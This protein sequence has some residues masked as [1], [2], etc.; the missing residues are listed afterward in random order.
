MSVDAHIIFNLVP[1]F[2]EVSKFDNNLIGFLFGIFYLGTYSNILFLRSRYVCTHNM[3]LTYAYT[4]RN[5]FQNQHPKENNL[6]PETNI[7]DIKR[8]M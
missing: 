2:V 7:P 8:Y 6:L 3:D 4:E 5:M 1:R